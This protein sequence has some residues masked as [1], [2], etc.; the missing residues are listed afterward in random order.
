M[1]SLRDIRQKIKGVATTQQITGAMKMMSTARLGRAIEA[2]NLTRDYVARLD[3]MVQSIRRELPDFNHPCLNK[4]QVKS[5]CMIVIGGERG[6]CGGFNHELHR[7]ALQT[8]KQHP[9]A[10]KKLIAIGRKP[11]RF[12][13]QRA[14]PL[15]STWPDLGIKS[16]DTELFPMA[17]QVFELF[18][19]GKTD[20]VNLIYTNF[21]SASRKHP[22]CVKL[23]PVESDTTHAQTRS[24]TH[25]TFEFLPSPE[26]L[27]E[28]IMPRYLRNLLQRAIVESSA[29]EQS[30]RMTAMT[31]ATDRA[32]EII[33]DLKLDLNRSRQALITR[34][35]AEVISG[36]Q[37]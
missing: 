26:L 1:A 27:F 8:I 37:T 35:I 3:S 23:L 33:E 4:R 18:M 6:L 10:D 14:V 31:S 11:I 17:A 28:Q 29:A 9:A 21:I 16:L 34:E 24:T 7:F 30:A 12:F 25:Q 20:E 19:S 5:A 15:F 2:I 36:S 22:V 13:E 32:E